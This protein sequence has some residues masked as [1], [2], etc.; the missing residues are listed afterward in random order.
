[1]PK[2]KFEILLD[3]ASELILAISHVRSPIKTGIMTGV[4]TLFIFMAAVA[5][6]GFFG[7][8]LIAFNQHILDNYRNKTKYCEETIA[9]YIN[10]NEETICQKY[11]SEHIDQICEPLINNLNNLDNVKSK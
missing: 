11:T 8:G 10:K 6:I 1:M 3:K 4:A 2:S 5:T 9:V 7:E